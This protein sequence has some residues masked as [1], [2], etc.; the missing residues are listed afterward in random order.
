MVANI[1]FYY[2]VQLV[3]K[4]FFVN[5]IYMIFNREF[6]EITLITEKVGHLVHNRETA[7]VNIT[8]GESIA[9]CRKLN[10]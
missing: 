10:S 3:L 1:I 6:W 5:N 2:L 7:F 8:Q 4:N 9:R